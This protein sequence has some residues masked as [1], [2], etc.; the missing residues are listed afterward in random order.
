MYILEC[1]SAKF[2]TIISWSLD[3]KSVIVHNR[4]AFVDI[5]IGTFFKKG[6]FDSFCRKMRRWGFTTKSVKHGDDGEDKWA[7]HHP[8]FNKAGSFGC[9][10]R[11]MTTAKKTKKSDFEKK[12]FLDPPMAEVPILLS[13]DHYLGQLIQVIHSP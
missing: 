1:L 11:V 3:G 4:E 9:C 6:T 10:E 8:D 7:F 13:I 5:I 2:G 12:K